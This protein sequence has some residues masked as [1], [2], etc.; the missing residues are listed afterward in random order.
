MSAVTHERQHQALPAH[1][2]GAFSR[3]FR[4]RTKTVLHKYACCRIDAGWREVVG[5]QFQSDSS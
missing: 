2:S 5:V 3:P 4:R 1:R